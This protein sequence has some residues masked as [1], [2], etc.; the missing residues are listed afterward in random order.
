MAVTRSTLAERAQNPHQPI[1][2]RGR[3][4]ERV[5]LLLTSAAILAAV[6]LTVAAK[7]ARVATRI[8]SRVEGS[9][10]ERLNLS[11]LDR[12][13][14]LLPFLQ[15]VSSPAE[16]Q[17]IA[18]KIY[19]D[20]R[21]GPGSVSHVGEIG[22][23]RVPIHDVL[24]THG[25]TG[26]QARAH[27]VQSARP[28][29]ET[30][31]LLDSTQLA[32][33]KPFFVVRDK[34][35]FRN[36]LILWS[37]LFFC[38]FWA[39]HIFWSVRATGGPQY[40][41]PSV[42][43]L[44]GIGMTLM[45]TLR[46]PV[47][48][49]LAFSTF[50]QGVAG[51][52]VVLAL[53]S[54]LD[55]RR[56]S[57]RL[58]YVFLIATFVLSAG[59]ILFGSGPTGSDA[60][61]NLLGFQPAEVIRVLI[62]F[63]LAGYFAERWEFLRT[64]RDQ[65]KGLERISRW[66]E[67]PR[68]E[69]LLPVA[70]G[71]VVSLAFFFLQKD[72]GPALLIACL[73]LAMYAV[74]RDR[75]L[76]ALIGLI[77][78]LCGFASGYFLGF[79]KNVAG[80]VSMWLSPWDNSV[81]GG[82]QVAHSLWAFATGGAFGTGLGLGDPQWMPAAH[83]DL[84]LA[85]LGEEWGFLGV[86]A[87]LALY[88]AVVWFGIRVAL[89]AR[90]DY[91]FFLA[92]GLTL[93]FALQILLIAG[94]VLG[95][96]PLSGVVVPFL[97]YGRTGLITNFAIIG[98]LFSLSREISATQDTNTTEPF[99]V[100][101]R[102]ISYVI[103]GL[104]ACLLLKAFYIQVIHADATAGASALALQADGERRYEYNPRLLAVAHSIPRGTIYDRNRIPL[105]T[106]NWNEIAQNRDRYSGMGLSVSE[107]PATGE[108]RYYPLGPAAFHLLGDLQT[109][110]NWAARNSSYAE[111]DFMQTLQGY[112]DRA[113][114]VVVFDSRTRSS[115]RILR[116]D[117]RE[118][119]PLLRHRWQPNNPEV[120]KVLDRDRNLH[121]TID[122]R[123]QL[124]TADLLEHQLRQLGR[125]KGAV[126][127]LDPENGDLL[128]SVSYPWPNPSLSVAEP[129][130]VDALLDRARYGLYPP[131]SSFKIVTAIAALRKDP[132]NADQIYECKRLPDGRTG[133][134][135]Q[136][137]KRP[138]HDD[139]K[140]AA[141]HGAIAM[142]AAIVVSCN[143]YFAQLGTYKVGPEALL[144]TATQLGIS[145]ANPSDVKT[146]RAEMPQTSYGQGQV[147]ATPFQMARVAATIAHGGSMPF[148]RWVTDQTNPRQD[149]PQAILNTELSSQVGEDMRDVVTSGTGRS[150][151]LPDIA[152]AGKTGT[153][154]LEHAP[155]HAWFIG[156]AP[157]GGSHQLAFSVLV[158]NGQ[159]GSTAAAPLA[160]EV[161]KAAKTLG[162]LQ[163]AP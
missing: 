39:V 157:Y 111:R 110:A 65:R 98:I 119:L 133:A 69:Y 30:I 116:Y 102:E 144:D 46:D 125:T 26:L 34:S 1:E 152:M 104:G 21:S 88:A 162:Y 147:V 53:A 76:F 90:S 115:Q 11:T 108:T 150:A 128:A 151:N 106:S 22:Q 67:V 132:G 79:P 99:R 118:L 122:A 28:G 101:V 47:R 48:D 41:L 10:S 87:V 100:P 153:A 95:L 94:G 163:G 146:L 105:A 149:P 3:A 131:G 148:G 33:L 71:V 92:L 126:V 38:S 54:T 42:L 159:Y 114:A 25:L 6:S 27:Q 137:W 60:K 40:V 127:V 82:E 70:G 49:T 138:I 141:P 58:S 77:V 154:E 57:G 5:L 14:Q 93:A 143:A 78:I 86:L 50:A 7:M 59:L 156:F 64:L 55:Y 32:R 97:S 18:G 66:V 84:I 52:C 75:Y 17:Y 44:S 124:K 62:V 61:V 45:I 83:T 103:A 121:L 4:R 68:L 72:L 158:E 142:R 120:K 96:I 20:I 161:M 35:Q 140:D 155:S 29:A 73:F 51:G 63:F 129:D 12:R 145:I 43:L 139:V 37:V 80:R 81:R 135:I 74:A 160:A 16:R 113:S 117:L 24:R 109:R 2:A 23:I 107:R 13:E 56:I 36:Q 9:D 112:D 31:L 134:F 8:D 85:A 136:G 130:Q 15:W 91:N 19:E 123:L 89:R